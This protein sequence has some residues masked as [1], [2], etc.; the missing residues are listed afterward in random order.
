MALEYYDSGSAGG[1]RKRLARSKLQSKMRRLALLPASAVPGPKSGGVV[2]WVNS[3]DIKS[4]VSVFF[5]R[6]A[7]AARYL[8]WQQW[9]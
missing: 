7:S 8:W 1:H 5:G 9:R 3:L 4:V 6:R 2:H